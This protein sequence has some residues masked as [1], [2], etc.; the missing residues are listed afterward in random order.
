[1]PK[2]SVSL[3]DCDDLVNNEPIKTCDLV[4]NEPIKTRDFVDELKDLI[5]FNGTGNPGLSLN[6]ENVYYMVEEKKC[7]VVEIGG[8]IDKH[9]YA[10]FV[11]FVEAV[12]CNHVSIMEKPNG[13]LCKYYYLQMGQSNSWAK[14]GRQQHGPKDKSNSLITHGLKRL[15]TSQPRFYNFLVLLL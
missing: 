1:M 9:I 10:N 13:M 4:N 7:E 11:G 8:K 12:T 14:K 2:K 6:Q 3:L 5:T 15:F